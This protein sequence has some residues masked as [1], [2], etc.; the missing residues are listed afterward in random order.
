MIEIRFAE[1]PEEK[2]MVKTLVAQIN[3]AEPHETV[4]NTAPIA[5]GNFKLSA[6]EVEGGFD[7]EVTPA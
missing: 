7:L 6:T 4:K 3:G 2:A 5:V 1:T